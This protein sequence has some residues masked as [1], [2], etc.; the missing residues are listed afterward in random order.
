MLRASEAYA[1]Q[2]LLGVGRMKGGVVLIGA[3]WRSCRIHRMAFLYVEVTFRMAKIKNAAS[4]K[5]FSSRENLCRIEK[6]TR[7]HLICMVFYLLLYK[8]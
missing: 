8:T 3:V 4:Q 2:R 1:I 7:K 5:I 6:N